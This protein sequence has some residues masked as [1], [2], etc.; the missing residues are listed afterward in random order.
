MGWG[1]L[2]CG[3]PG[4]CPSRGPGADGPPHQPC[5]SSGASG[6]PLGAICPASLDLGPSAA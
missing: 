4:L 5:P 6:L 1:R 2:N 3:D